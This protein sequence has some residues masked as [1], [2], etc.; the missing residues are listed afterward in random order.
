M[1]RPEAIIIG[2]GISGAS[3]A[4]GLAAHGSV[5]LAERESQPGYHSTGR[6][7]AM[8]M[9]SYGTP[10]VRALTRA[11]H[12]FYAQPPAG[13]AD[14]P[15]L[16]PR[17]ALYVA[18]Q[19]QQD[20]LDRQWNDL[21]ATGCAVER[22]DAAATLARVPVLRSAGLLGAIAEADAMDIDVHLLHHGWLAATR[23]A[24]ASVWLGAELASARRVGGG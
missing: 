12:A 3:L 24:G 16:S 5:L 4:A 11:S 14:A 15:I 20:L 7:A 2:A 1:I 9:A 13:F 6:S 18:W 23:R 19:G 10:Q 8:F 21:H 17:G 22:L